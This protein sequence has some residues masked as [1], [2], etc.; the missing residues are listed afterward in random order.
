MAVFQPDYRFRRAWDIP[1]EWLRDKGIT[2]LLLDVDNTLTTHDNPDVADGVHGWLARMRAAGVRL[3]ILSNNHPA[4][5]EPFAE[6]LGVGC[7]ADAAKPLGGGVRRARERLGA[8]ARE[9]A[10]VG[11]QV[12]TDVLCANLAGAVSILVEPI[13]LEPFPFFKLKRRLE[14]LVLR[15]G[16]KGTH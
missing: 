5:V 10:I 9:I 14:K 12:F 16:R 6:K 15:G 1:P 3:F 13:E 4:R 8:D 11:D 2:V 7:I